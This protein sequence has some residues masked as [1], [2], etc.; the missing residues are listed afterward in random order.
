MTRRA[1][2][3]YAARV[4]VVFEFVREVVAK[5]QRDDALA[6]GAALAFYMLFSLAPLLVLV[7][8]VAGLALGNDAVHGRV[9]AA[10]TDA[11]GPDAAGTVAGMLERM[12]A[13]GAGIVA[14]VASIATMLLGASGVFGHLQSVLN[15]MFEAP[16]P[17]GGGFRNVARRRLAAFA[18][19]LGIGVLLG[20]SMLATTLLDAFRP[21]LAARVPALAPALPWLDV[22]VSIAVSATL[23]AAI[24]RIL[25]DARLGWRE[26]ALGGLLTAVLFAAGKGLIG[27]YLSRSGGTSVFGAAASLVLL[28]LWI[29]WSAQIL[30]VGAEVTA[31]LTRRRRG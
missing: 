28:L 31:V 7:I 12:R 29:Y 3:G 2:T 20:A 4:R 22:V 23:F 6:Q 9:L 5:W 14:S 8:A 11:V 21:V 17:A 25:P 27:L 26:T 13:P 19:V 10:I 16:P 1:A 24:F 30:F 18:M 15:R